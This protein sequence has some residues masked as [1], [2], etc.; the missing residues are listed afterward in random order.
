MDDAL[1]EACRQLMST[2]TEQER[3]LEA[4]Q[5]AC[6]EV[7]RQESV[8]PTAST[9]LIVIVLH[10]PTAQPSAGVVAVQMELRSRIQA[11]GAT[12]ILHPPASQPA[13]AG[14]PAGVPGAAPGEAQATAASPAAVAPDSQFNQYVLAREMFR[15]RELWALKARLPDSAFSHF[16]IASRAICSAFETLVQATD[17]DE[18]PAGAQPPKAHFNQIGGLA[19]TDLGAVAGAAAVV[20]DAAEP[21]ATAEGGSAEL[22]KD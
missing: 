7:L 8:H 19:P 11:S 12:F 21:P 2:W 22:A 10:L 17:A 15:I 6:S 14:A 16:I 3:Q 18:P 13:A 4:T 9:L 1:L 20:T 5:D